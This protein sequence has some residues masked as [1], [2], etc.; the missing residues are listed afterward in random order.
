LLL[1][2]DELL[3]Y[4]RSRN[5]QALILDLAFLREL[6]EVPLTA[7]FRFIGGLQESLFDNPRFEFVADQL[8]RVRDRFEQVRIAR[9]DIAF[10]V[11]ERLLRKTDTQLA[12]ITTH[13]RK[14][15]VLYPALA[16][17]LTEYARLFPIHPAYIDT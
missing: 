5:E 9:Q 11:A 13:L 3:D 16:D 7:R 4:L 15:T 2:V 12:Q 8:R 17:H 6:G 14:F 10:V 1:V